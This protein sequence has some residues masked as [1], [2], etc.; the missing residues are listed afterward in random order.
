MVPGASLPCPGGLA[1]VISG[2]GPQ[3]LLSPLGFAQTAARRAEISGP[4]TGWGR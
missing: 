3:E 4:D 1:E 2:L